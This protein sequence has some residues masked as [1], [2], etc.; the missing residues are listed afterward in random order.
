MDMDIVQL[1]QQCWVGHFRCEGQVFF[2]IFT[3]SEKRAFETLTEFIMQVG[4]YNLSGEMPTCMLD[5][6][7]LFFPELEQ[8]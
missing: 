3:D 2:S 7:Q 4:T 6:D 8:T 5:G 1:S